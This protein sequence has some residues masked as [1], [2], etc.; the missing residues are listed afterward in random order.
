MDQSIFTELSLVIVIVAMVSLVMRFLRQPLIL[1]Y[2]LT[3]ILVGPSFLHL[4]HS[5][6]AFDGFSTIGIALLLFIIGLGMNIN[7]M[8][9]VGSSIFTTAG[10][11]LVTIGSIGFAAGHF[12]LGFTLTEAYIVALALF[13]SSTIIIV[14]ALTDKKEQDRLHGQI[15]IGVILLDD[16]VATLALLFVAAGQDQTVGLNELGQLFGRG[17]LMLIGLVLVSKFVL[18]RVVKAIAASQESLFLFAIAW[19]FGVASLFEWTGFSIEVGALFAGVALASLPY[20]QEIESRLKPLRDFFVVLFF[21][22]LGESLEVAHLQPALWP[23]LLLSFIVI[24][25]KP[26]TITSTLG[27]LGYPKRVAFKAGIH[28]SQISEFSIVLIVLAAANGLVDERLSAI[29]T[30]VAMVT[31]TTSSYLTQYDTQLF[32][33]FNRLKLFDFLF[34]RD[35]KH[36]ERKTKVKYQL[37]LFGYH[38]GGH[39]FIRTFKR[40]KKRFLVVDYDPGVV[41]LLQHEQVPCL[42]GDASDAE[43]LEEIGVQNAKLIVSTI[44]DSETNQEL[45]RHLNFYNPEAVIICNANSYEE[46]LQLYELGCSYVMIPHFAGSERLSSLIVRNGIDRQHF[47]R[48]RQRHLEHLEKNHP[49]TLAE[50]A[51]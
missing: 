6:E 7:V 19:G 17:V 25:L 14:K 50:E 4:I 37:F 15:A 48:Y 39:E 35:R 38:R 22:T 23:A 16:L 29:V 5:K 24:V 36:K 47:D 20:A 2:I 11:L 3:G 26:A 33:I 10:A 28:L 44:T 32:A 34:A 40:L 46:A 27:L 45:I 42:Y 51:L 41:E 1:G 8:K 18:P 13:F 30:I 9:R 43:L 49:L 12:I 31:I 21:I